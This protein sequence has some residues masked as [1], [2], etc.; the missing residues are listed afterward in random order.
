MQYSTAQYNAYL[1][2]TNYLLSI[3]SESTQVLDIPEQSRDTRNYCASLAHK[4]YSEIMSA[5]SIL[6]IVKINWMRQNVLRSAE[7]RPIFIHCGSN[8][9]G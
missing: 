3:Y 5:F 6:R 1:I 8:I 7:I 2:S 9:F 4:G